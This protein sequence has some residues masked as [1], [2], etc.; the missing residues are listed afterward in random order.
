VSEDKLERAEA[1][2]VKVDVGLPQKS[3]VPLDV[4]PVADEQKLLS[5]EEFVRACATDL[6]DYDD[7]FKDVDAQ[8]NPYQNS[9]H[10]YNEWLR[11]F[12]EYISW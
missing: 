4:H 7:A 12:R 6:F 3:F 11:G 10:T 1:Q 2:E 8:T 9:K 5:R